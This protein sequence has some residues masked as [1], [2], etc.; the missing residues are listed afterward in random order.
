MRPFLLVLGCL[1]AC[2]PAWAEDLQEPRACDPPCRSGFTCREGQCISLCNPPCRAGERCVQ[3][4]CEMMPRSV[5]VTAKEHKSYLGVMGV[6][7]A[8]VN[9]SASNQGEVRLE[10]GSRYSALQIGPVFG[11][12]VVMVRTAIHGQVPFQIVPPLPLYVVPTVALGYAYGWLDDG[13]DGQLQ[14][15]FIVPGVRLR[16]FFIEQLALV[17]DLIQMQI[18]FVRL[19][20]NNAREMYRMDAVPL[21]WNLGLGLAFFY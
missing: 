1:L 20:S 4:E 9:E 2:P 18:N 3:G 21:T 13:M 10:F 14:D 8:A 19:Y 16:F 5:R 15:I 17:A 6:F 11:D 7:Q 12:K